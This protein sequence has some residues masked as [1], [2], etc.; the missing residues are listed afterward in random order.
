MN[1]FDFL[2]NDKETLEQN[3]IPEFPK[4]LSR[5]QSLHDATKHEYIS[6]NK[7]KEYQTP[8]KQPI[9]KKNRVISIENHIQDK[10]EEKRIIRIK[11]IPSKHISRFKQSF[12]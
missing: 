1:N 2:D 3:L 8:A 6:K 5:T 11:K 9:I 12:K 7:V 4:V 10:S